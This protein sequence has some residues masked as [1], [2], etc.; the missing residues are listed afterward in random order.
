MSTVFAVTVHYH[1][2]ASGKK[3]TQFVG[4]DE[5]V[6][7]L[8]VSATDNATVMTSLAAKLGTAPSGQTL[9]I[10]SIGNAGPAGFT[11]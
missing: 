8:I 9:V 10:D 3:Q 6:A 7:H 1:Y 4:A 5:G 11:Q 2:E